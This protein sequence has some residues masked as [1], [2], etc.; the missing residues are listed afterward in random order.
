M[1][2]EIEITDDDWESV[3]RNMLRGQLMT[4]GL[5]YARLAEALALIGVE[6]TEISV[7]NKVGR[8]RFTFMFFLQAMA[9]IG[10]TRILI[11]TVEELKTGHGLGQGGAQTFA[12]KTPSAE[13]G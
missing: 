5:S 9:A 1:T 12:R 8:G 6:E 4:K 3:A 7:K 13:N 10:T 11:P 2:Q